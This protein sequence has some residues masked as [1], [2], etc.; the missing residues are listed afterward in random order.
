MFD[1]KS[2]LDILLKGAQQP[3]PSSPQPQ[4]GGGMGSLGDILGQL[5]KQLGGPQAQAQAPH[6]AP[7]NSGSG[8]FG[9]LGELLEQLQK[10]MSG[11][12]AP[13]QSP[14]GGSGGSFGGLGEIL[15]QI[16]KQM[17]QAGQGGSAPH[18]QAGQMPQPA[19]HQ[20]QPPQG[21]AQQGGGL[22]DILG[23]ILGQAT[24]G[25]KEGA[26]RINE[27]T[28]ASDRVRE[29]LGQATGKTPENLL[30][31]LQ[32]WIRNNPGTAAAG[33]GGLGAVLLGTR[34]GRGVVGNAVRLGSL[35]LIGGL[36]YKAWQNYQ[37][38]RP[39]IGPGDAQQ[40]VHEAAP[41]GSGFE[42]A[43]ISNET[44]TLYIRSM[45]AAAAADGRIDAAEQGRILGGLQQAGL[46]THAQQFLE[47]EIQSPADVEDLA[48]ACSSPAEAVQVY[49]AARLAID[50]DTRAEKEFL[51]ALAERLGIDAQLAAHIDATARAA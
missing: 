28:G 3:P 45:I 7:G 32:E 18:G 4:Q 46:G 51:A 35:A 14:Q 44:A 26:G 11:A 2:I 41:I 1:A 27:A 29:A 13:A 31:E 22:M 16:Q 8:G 42:P 36:A 47:R 15:E 19:P 34:T 37:A 17:G 48:A 5:Q 10:Q 43:A 9:G 30:A 23:Q 50:P 49:T 12:Q 20:S 33:A 6:A 21:D 38:G 40:R 24:S 25:V 39:L